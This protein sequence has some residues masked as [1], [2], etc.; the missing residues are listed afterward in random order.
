LAKYSTGSKK[1][2]C[3]EELSLLYYPGN[4]VLANLWAKSLVVFFVASWRQKE[5]FSGKSWMGKVMYVSVCY[6]YVDRTWFLITP[7]PTSTN[8]CFSIRISGQPTSRGCREK[9]QR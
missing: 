5:H 9:D 6:N 1:E 2:F 7:P 4:L 8:P 3:R